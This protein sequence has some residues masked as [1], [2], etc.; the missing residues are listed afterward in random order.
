MRRNKIEPIA[1]SPIFIDT[2]AS[3]PILR[4]VMIGVAERIEFF[5]RPLSLSN[6]VN[7]SP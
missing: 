1:K 6:N 3:T 5:Q 2:F 4:I 7:I